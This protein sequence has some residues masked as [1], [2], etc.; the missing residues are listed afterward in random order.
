M[1]LKTFFIFCSIFSFDIISVETPLD[2]G[3]CKKEISSLITSW[4]GLGLWEKR[5]VGI[6]ISPTDSAG[7]WVLV[8]YETDKSVTIIKSSVKNEIKVNFSV[9]C[10]RKLKVLE[11]KGTLSNE[12]FKGD[13]YLFSQM[14]KKEG[15]IYLWSSHMPLSVKGL[16]QIQKAAGKLK[17]PVIYLQDEKSEILKTKDLPLYFR[18]Q[19]KSFE[20]KMRNAY[21]HYPTVLGFKD[22]RIINTIK[23]GYENKDGY[24]K[25]IKTIFNL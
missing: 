14:S 7:K 11:K 17:L 22:G 4:K 18:T 24:E 13:R 2:F 19:I 15:L 25:D 8:K 23:Y 12:E 1:N 10:K 16:Y 9:N 21:L 3:V 20:L 6:F 5:G